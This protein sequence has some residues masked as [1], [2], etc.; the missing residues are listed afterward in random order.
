[1]ET[2]IDIKNI[3]DMKLACSE[4][5]H[6]YDKYQTLS[7][8]I[9]NMH[10]THQFYQKLSRLNL[11]S[12]SITYSFS[13]D[14]LEQCHCL[15]KTIKELSLS[16]LSN[17]TRVSVQSICQLVNLNELSIGGY[18]S[19]K[20]S[21]VDKILQHCPK[22]SQLYLSYPDIDL[23]HPKSTHLSV[24][25]FKSVG[26]NRETDNNNNIDIY[27]W[28]PNLQC[29]NLYSGDQYNVDHIHQLT[30]LQDL[31][32]KFY[33]YDDQRAS[34]IDLIYPQLIK[35][36]IMID[37]IGVGRYSGARKGCLRWPLKN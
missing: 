27:Q 34:E 29:L 28:F 36:N 37:P 18:I 9:S 6:N 1:M 22:I 11:N 33:A 32:L 15:P 26:F 17:L 24:T 21:D 5:S 23:S 10:L 30:D 31:N 8:N 14:S 3:N 7:I 35:A 25:E 12:L 13:G 2:N 19:I 16:L 20:M 4:F